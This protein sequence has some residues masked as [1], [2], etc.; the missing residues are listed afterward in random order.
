[1]VT[2][3]PIVEELT[4]V[5]FTFLMMKHKYANVAKRLVVKESSNYTLIY[6]V[7]RDIKI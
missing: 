3:V 4:E 2:C 7:C 1:M 6:V 5:E